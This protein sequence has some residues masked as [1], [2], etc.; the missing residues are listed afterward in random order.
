LFFVDEQWSPG[1]SS[2]VEFVSQNPFEESVA[3]LS[4]LSFGSAFPEST[5]KNFFVPSESPQL[6][7]PSIPFHTAHYPQSSA[8]YEQGA[9]ADDSTAYAQGAYADDSTAYAQGAYADDSAAYAEAANMPWFQDSPP[10]LQNS[11][12][13]VDEASEG[14]DAFAMSAPEEEEEIILLS[15]E[16]PPEEDSPAQADVYNLQVA[17]AKSFPPKIPPVVSP[18]TPSLLTPAIFYDTAEASWSSP[19]SESAVSSLASLQVQ[20]LYEVVLYTM[21]GAVKHGTFQDAD[22]SQPSV[23]LQTPEETEQVAVQHIKAVYFMKPSEGAASLPPVTGAYWKVVFNDGRRVEGQL[24]K[25]QEDAAGF[26]L[27]PRQEK[28]PTACLYINRSAVQEISGIA[29]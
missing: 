4:E 27:V 6:F 23:S 8:A 5:P 10:Q 18:G 7:F 22:L 29:S 12:W 28:S 16:L 25:P 9:Y 20:G 15:D 13:L 3:V 21:N 1:P 2:N 19:A 24:S 17:S 26:F 14:M 11:L